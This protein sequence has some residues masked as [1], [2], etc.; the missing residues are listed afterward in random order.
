MNTLALILRRGRLEY[1]GF[2]DGGA[3]VTEGASSLDAC[4]TDAAL[5]D[6]LREMG[7]E[8]RRAAGAEPEAAALLTPYGGSAF[9]AAAPA[10][11]QSVAR[12]EALASQAP[13]DAPVASHLARCW[14]NA[15]PRTPLTLLFETAFFTALPEREHSYGLDAERTNALSARR[16]GYHGLFHAAA[17][18]HGGRARRIADGPARL[19]SIV[20]EPKPEL[21]AVLGRRPLTVTSGA[22]PLE[23]L[24]GETSGGELDAGIVL[25]LAR[26][27]G[28]GPEQI[29]HVLTRESGLLGLT[30]RRIALDA[31]FESTEPE[32]ELARDL[33][34]YRLLLACGAGIAALGG[35]DGI[36]F[37]GRYA[38]LGER[39]GPWLAAKI[40]LKSGP[41]RWE[42][43]AT[44]LARLV[45][46]EGGPA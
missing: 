27:K 18:R 38:P 25:A 16:Y 21:A 1:A 22:T 46:D 30:G 5:V 41:V 39:L 24:P 13:L 28:W 31:L 14:M 33:M 29:N 7:A 15:F 34:R 3:A 43:L 6:R 12:L 45:A 4:A 19:L 40:R 44:P 42:C 37:S 2:V 20:L 26:E 17:C 9:P 11:A 23:G 8:F 36:L 10:D 32:L 35:L